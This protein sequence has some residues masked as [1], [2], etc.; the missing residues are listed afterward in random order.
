MII[1]KR[2]NRKMKESKL[3]LLRLLIL[4]MRS[5]S[6]CEEFYAQTAEDALMSQFL[7][8]STGTYVD[9]GA[10][11]P[12]A[13]SNTYM[14]YKRGWSGICIDP[15]SAN[16]KLFKIL[17]RRDESKQF[18]IGEG[19]EKIDF[20]EFEP[21]ELSTANEKVALSVAK[22]TGVTL[23]AFSK[24]SVVTLSQVVPTIGPHD[25]SMLSID[26]EGFDLEVLKSND[27]ERFKPR[28]VCVEEW[29][30]TLDKN[31]ESEIRKFLVTQGYEHSAYS[32]L[33]SIF[34]HQDFL[35]TRRRL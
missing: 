35:A 22:L 26:V 9:I 11:H 15:I 27:W 14:Y 7:P 4:E 34:V 17:R 23:K 10:G 30:S 19:T 28:V 18:L 13:G 8:E 21:Y 6:L 16:I 24:I 12:I 31:Q 3:N 33:S 2:F 1:P 32:G 5:R 20:W 29:P 25:P